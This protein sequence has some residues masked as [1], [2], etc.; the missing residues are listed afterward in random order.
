MDFESLKRAAVE[1]PE[2]IRRWASGLSE[3][4]AERV[5][6]V[7]R[8]L[9]AQFWEDLGDL[10]TGIDSKPAPAD[11][12]LS[13][14]ED[15]ARK[16]GTCE[17][18]MVV[19]LKA[20]RHRLLGE[21]GAAEEQL[22]AAGELAPKCRSAKPGRPN[23]CHLEILWRWGMLDRSLG[24][25]ADGLAKVQ[26]T[27]DG[28]EELGEPG[29]NLDRD[30]IAALT[31][32][33]AQIRFDLKDYGGSAADFGFCLDRFPLGS[34]VWARTQHNLACALAWTG[35]KGRRRA[36]ELMKKSALRFRKREM[37]TEKAVHL[38]LD[39]QLKVALGKQRGIERLKEALA[40]YREMKMP[41]KYWCVALDLARAYFPQR[42][43]IEKF[44]KKIEPTFLDLVRD[45]RHLKL[46]GELHKLCQGCPRP[47]TLSTLDRLL[48][49]IRARVADEAALPPSLLEPPGNP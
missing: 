25:L 2:A 44:L 15:R 24:L 13:A 14:M 16:L 33:R 34:D 1:D 17:T 7:L 36:Y 5:D 23:P 21:L 26:E 46:F 9:E 48:R 22:T 40:G 3:E 38:V 20:Y 45:E 30:G 37:T 42:H 19:C 35:E 39:G 41:Y 6:E 43:E 12:A 49:R 47:D 11:K 4:E 18:V 32:A 29:H 28:Y 27:L 8:A 31:F 10:V